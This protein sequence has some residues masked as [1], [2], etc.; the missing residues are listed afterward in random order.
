MYL[1]AHLKYS[2]EALR[3]GSTEA[4]AVV[5]AVGP[6]D[7]G[8]S[9]LLS[10]V[11]VPLL[12]GR[13]GKAYRFITGA[14]AFNTEL[15]RAET[16]IV[17]DELL[18][19]SYDARRNLANTIKNIAGDTT[20]RV[21]GKNKDVL[22]V[23]T[24]TRLFM[25]LNSGEEDC[26]PELTDSVMDKIMLFKAH[27]FEMPE[28]LPPLPR[29]RQEKTAFRE[30]L[31]EELPHFAQELLDLVVPEELMGRR[32]MVRHYANPDIAEPLIE[33]SPDEELFCLIQDV[34]FNSKGYMREMDTDRDGDWKGSAAKLKT[35]LMSSDKSKQ[36]EYFCRSALALGTRLAS[37]SAKHPEYVAYKRTKHDRVWVIKERPEEIDIPGDEPQ[38]K[39]PASDSFERAKRAF[40]RGR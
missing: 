38:V 8:K 13:K 27:E 12:G 21:E 30:R 22:N 17:D 23:P 40:G 2:L 33:T 15:Q 28:G 11:I 39:P 24:F 31:Q 14:T 19:N 36:L 25:C 29:T 6:K 26:L 34:L 9:F 35:A 16:W 18:S 3:A 32:F 5:L 4:G 20:L 37:L 7:C 1:R 10:H